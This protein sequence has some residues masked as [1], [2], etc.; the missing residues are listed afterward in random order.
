MAATAT[1]PRSVRGVLTVSEA[2]AEA[3]FP[4]SEATIYRWLRD[5]MIEGVRIGGRVFI[6]DSAWET[7]LE[8]CG[9]G[10]K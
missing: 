2:R 4:V 7:F 8:E 6:R 9:L 10:E 1:I 3:P 5:G